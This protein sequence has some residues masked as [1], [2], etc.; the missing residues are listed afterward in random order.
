M[1]TILELHGV[2]PAEDLV[3]HWRP[4]GGPGSPLAMRTCTACPGQRSATV[5]LPKGQPLP[6]PFLCSRE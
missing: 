3:E 2:E 4:R 1:L 5:G 6:S